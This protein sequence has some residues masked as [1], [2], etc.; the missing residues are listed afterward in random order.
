MASMRNGCGDDWFL[1]LDAVGAALKGY[2]HELADDAGLPQNIQAQ[3]PAVFAS[4][5]HEPAFSM[6]RATFCYWRQTDDVVWHKLGSTLSNDGSDD[7]LALIVSEPAAYKAWAEEYYEVS[8]SLA[9]VEALFAHQALD[10]ALVL[11]LNPD[12]DLS[13]VYAETDEIGYPKTVD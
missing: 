9:A 4:F 2:A 6:D 5:L 1:L 11:A 10:D 12:A 3:V 13:A 7:M 8:V